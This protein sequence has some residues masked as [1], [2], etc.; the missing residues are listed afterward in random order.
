MQEV[1]PP[2]PPYVQVPHP[3]GTDIGD[4]MAIFVD[5]SAPDPQK[6]V[7][8][9]EDL[10]KLRKLTQSKDEFSR[11]VREM[12]QADPVKYHWCFYSKL[13]W[14]EN[15]LKEDLYLQDR[16]KHVLDTYAFLTPVARAF[17]NEFRD[18]RY[19]HW[20]VTRYRKLSEYVFYRRVELSPQATADLTA[21]NAMYGM[22]REPGGDKTKSVLE[23]YGLNRQV[24]PDGSPG[25]ETATYAEATSQ[26]QSERAPA[27][28]QYSATDGAQPSPSPTPKPIWR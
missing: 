24:G 2:A 6:L 1:P 11:G 13:L 19:L 3:Q 5:S 7:G 8:C 28:E 20:A 12:V 14:L 4:L 26:E 10:F 18:S 16:Q 17:L 9:G 25:P 27:G 23:K 15:Q 22:Y 21:S